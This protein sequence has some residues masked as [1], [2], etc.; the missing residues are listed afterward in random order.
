MSENSETFN[1]QSGL[2]EAECQGKL[3][4]VKNVKK[5]A[6][7]MKP[8]RGSL[9]VLKEG[10]RTSLSEPT[11]HSLKLSIVTI[12]RN[13]AA[14]S[15]KTAVSHVSHRP[16]AEQ[17]TIIRQSHFPTLSEELCGDAV[18]GSTIWVTPPLN[19]R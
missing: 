7:M 10:E 4:F 3:V 11:Y 17:P 1:V 6:V 15:L 5:H 13:G 14:G 9:Y 12:M 2:N 19:G 18:S 8:N 16:I